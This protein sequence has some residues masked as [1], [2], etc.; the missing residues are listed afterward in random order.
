M[1]ATWFINTYG[2]YGGRIR[3]AVL[4]EPGGLTKGQLDAYMKRLNGSVS[5]L[6][7]AINDMTWVGQFVSPTTH[8]RADYLMMVQGIADW[9]AVHCDA[10]V[11]EPHWRFG[12]VAAKAMEELA[13]GGFD[14][15]TNL[16]S[17]APRVLF[18]RGDLNEANRLQDQ[19]EMAAAYANA[20]LVTIPNVGHCLIWE[21]PAE[22]LQHVR[23]YFQAIGFTGGQP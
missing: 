20:D 5:F 17:F 22:Y 16:G 9:P 11:P 2:T 8:A 18:L 14:W 23:A 10:S 12:A 7:R 19:Q 13:R 6:D 15:T 3:G 4:S 1:Y 21:R